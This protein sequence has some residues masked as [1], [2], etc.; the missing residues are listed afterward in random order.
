[1]FAGDPI[2]EMPF[3]I[4]NRQDGQDRGQSPRNRKRTK[5]SARPYRS[6]LAAC[7][8]LSLIAQATVPTLIR[9]LRH[10][11]LVE[12]LSHRL[13]KLYHGVDANIVHRIFHLGDMGL[14]D[15]G[16]LGEFALTEI[17]FDTV[18]PQIACKDLT[19]GLAFR[20]PLFACG[21]QSALSR[22]GRGGGIL[23]LWLWHGGLTIPEIVGK[24]ALIA[25]TL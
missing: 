11:Q 15:A 25:Q 8:G 12:R 21:R 2:A 14:G 10:E 17:G 3:S 13:G 9:R 19:L 4:R 16:V 24:C 18:P 5:N 6:P 23:R 1:M 20:R 22:L 7:S